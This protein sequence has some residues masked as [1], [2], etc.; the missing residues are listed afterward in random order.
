M[1]PNN[2]KHKAVSTRVHRKTILK[3]EAEMGALGDA[4]TMVVRFKYD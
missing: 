4:M 2:T 3:L 1:G